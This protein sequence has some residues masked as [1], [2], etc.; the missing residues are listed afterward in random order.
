MKLPLVI[1]F[2]RLAHPRPFWEEAP[3]SDLRLPTLYLPT[4]RLLTVAARVE[5]A[6]DRRPM[7][8]ERLVAGQTPF[9][10]GD[11]AVRR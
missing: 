7:S 8:H 2:T 10:D 5:A 6:A 4:T 3:T 11:G 1:S 9:D